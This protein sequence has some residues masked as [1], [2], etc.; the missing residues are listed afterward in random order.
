[1]YIK[2]LA[3]Y[4][5]YGNYSVCATYDFIIAIAIFKLKSYS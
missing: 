2:F 5:I 4:M 3:K 1:M